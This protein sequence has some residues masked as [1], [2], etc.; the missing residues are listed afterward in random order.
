MIGPYCLSILYM[1]SQAR[2][3]IPAAAVTFAAAVAPQDPLTHSAGPGIEPASWQCKDITNLVAPK[4]EP[5]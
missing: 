5:L 1:S 4:Q 2:D 3:Q